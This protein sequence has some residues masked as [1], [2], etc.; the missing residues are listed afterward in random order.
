M[1]S[2]TVGAPLAEL[3]INFGPA[4]MMIVPIREEATLA[5]LL[6]RDTVTATVRSL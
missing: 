3:L 5:V 2:A 1:A 6:E 4:R